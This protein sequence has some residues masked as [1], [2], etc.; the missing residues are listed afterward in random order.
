[1]ADVISMTA[2]ETHAEAVKPVFMTYKDLMSRWGMKETKFY[3]MRKNGDVP[4]I[5]QTP[6]GPRFRVRDVVAVE[7]SWAVAYVA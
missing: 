1:M 3:Q 5:I 2:D 7:E 4:P 6:F